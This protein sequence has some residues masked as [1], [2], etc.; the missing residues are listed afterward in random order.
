MDILKKQLAPITEKAWEEINEQAAEV[1]YSDLSVRKFADVEG[2][3][4]LDKGGLPLGKLKIPRN[5]DK[6][7]LQYGV[8]E[9]QA[10]IE[11]RTSF[12]LDLWELDNIERGARDIDLEPLEKAAK[13]LAAFEENT[14]YEG[15]KNANVSGLMKKSEHEVIAFPEDPA[16][17]LHAVTE[18][19]TKL[20]TSSIEGPYSLVLDIQKW[21]K[22][23]AYVNG[24]PLRLQLEEILGGKLILAPNLK[25]ALVVS[26][27]GGD[28]KLTLGQ[29]ISIGYE[30]HTRNEV[31]LYFSEAFTFQVL[32]AAAIVLMK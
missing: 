6:N 19:V 1:F 22:I 15:L 31:Q 3:V 27:R 9:V 28:F 14:I 29:D 5:Q 12:K 7:E 8:Q 20:K 17:I 23:S 2:P 4:G 21:E 11:V 32:E 26:E 16:N 18:A 25:G 10:F 30:A 13:R 24:Y